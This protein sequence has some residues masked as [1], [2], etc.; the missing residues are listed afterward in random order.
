[1]EG[2]DIKKVIKGIR[3]VYKSLKESI[4]EFMKGL[5]AIGF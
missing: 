5:Y 4:N 1:M 3:K 2:N